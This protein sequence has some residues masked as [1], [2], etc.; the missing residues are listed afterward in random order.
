MRILI[1]N[2]FYYN[3]G[4]DCIASMALE[5]LLKDKGHDVAFFSMQYAQNF[6]SEWESYFPSEVCF[7]TSGWKGKAKALTRILSS[8]EVRRKFTSLLDQFKPDVVHLNNIHSQLSPIIG[9]IA[10]RRNIKVVWTMHD[11]KLICPN[12]KCLH[13]GKVCSLCV[14][15]RNPIHVLKTKCM[16]GSFAASTMAYLEALV[17]NAN[18]LERNTDCFIAPSYFLADLMIKGGFP[19]DKINVVP[20]FI[21]HELPSRLPEKEDYYVYIGRLSEEKGLHTLLQVAESL[22]YEL[23][24]VGD[25]PLKGML[26]N[27]SSHVQFLGFK[28]WNQ[29]VPI[30]QKAKFL[31]VPSE[32]YEVFGLSNIEA[33]CLGTPVLGADIGGIPETIDVPSCG[34]LFEAGN[35][36]DLEDK[37]KLMFERSFNYKRIADVARERFSADNYYKEII[38]I[39]EQ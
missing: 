15:D 30:A 21:N 12:Y 27:C 3:R 6:E 23:H 5:K 35:K 31:V 33:Q 20:N 34:M 10:H 13:N 11:Y 2:K 36:I 14:K 29:L 19:S 9:E 28:N 4:G 1:A 17:W 32:W 24:I 8:K 16:K 39:Y 22:P 37:I 26:P 7:Q 38:K 25:G 18:R